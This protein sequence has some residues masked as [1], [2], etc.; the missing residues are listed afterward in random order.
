MNCR[1]AIKDDRL[2]LYC[3]CD[4]TLIFLEEMYRYLVLNEFRDIHYTE[5]HVVVEDKPWM[6]TQFECSGEFT[7]TKFKKKLE[8]HLKT[9]NIIRI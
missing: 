4:G 8:N 9:N 5:H 1:Y 7:D 6:R 3:T 2:Y